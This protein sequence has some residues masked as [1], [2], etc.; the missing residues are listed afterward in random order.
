MDDDGISENRLMLG[1]LTIVAIAAIIMFVTDG[2]SI[3]RSSQ[4]VERI[5]VTVAQ[6]IQ[7]DV[8]VLKESS[9]ERKPTYWSVTF[10][11][12]DTVNFTSA[13]LLARIDE[14]YTLCGVGCTVET[15]IGSSGGHV[16]LTERSDG[17]V[18]VDWP[19]GSSWDFREYLPNR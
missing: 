4:G 6:V 17:R 14:T 13:G 3:A 19:P 1:W 12:G 16:T 9:H 5:G 15:E 8:L 11:H 10:Y 7:D 18:D 2:H